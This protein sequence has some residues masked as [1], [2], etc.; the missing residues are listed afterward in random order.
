MNEIILNSDHALIRLREG[1]FAVIDLEDVELARKYS[2]FLRTSKT[3]PRGYAC[4]A[5]GSTSV[6]LHKLLVPGAEIVDHRDRDSLNNRRKNLREST[7]LLNSVNRSSV[8][9]LGYRGI[10]KKCHKYRASI[11]HEGKLL[12]LGSADT[13]EEAARLYDEAAVELYGEFAVTNFPMEDYL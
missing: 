12:Y 9:S 3:S 1:V 13:P 6:Y 7:R 11:K 2:W 10:H 4:A 8:N 5:V